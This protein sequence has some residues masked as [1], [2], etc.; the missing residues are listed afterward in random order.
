MVLFVRHRFATGVWDESMAY[1]TAEGTHVPATTR[2]LR[3]P[4]PLRPSSDSRVQLVNMNLY[5]DSDAEPVAAIPVATSTASTPLSPTPTVPRFPVNQDPDDSDD[6]VQFISAHQPVRIRRPVRRPV[7]VVLSSDDDDENTVTTNS[8]STPQTANTAPESQPP[9]NSLWSPP[10]SP[11]PTNI[12]CITP[13]TMYHD[14]PMSPDFQP[15]LTPERRRSEHDSWSDDEGM[16]SPARA[17]SWDRGSGQRI[18]ETLRAL[19]APTSSSVTTHAD[20]Q[21]GLLHR[22]SGS[23]TRRRTHRTDREDEDW[24]PAA[25]SASSSSRRRRHMRDDSPPPSEWPRRSNTA[26]QWRADEDDDELG[27]ERRRMR[28]DCHRRRHGRDSHRRHRASR[29]YRDAEEAAGA[30][31]GPRSSHKRPATA[32]P[33]H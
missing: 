15:A 31:C 6:S 32:A 23:R 24:L 11:R 27:R 22:R 12:M 25:S 4:G 3:N 29:R 19:A 7:L 17:T 30:S 1:F 16:D 9:A 13:P 26:T 2:R 14:T 20:E 5:S 33:R 28:E 21:R 10:R 8:V 18:R